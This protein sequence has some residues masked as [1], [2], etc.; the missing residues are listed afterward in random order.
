MIGRAL[1]A[2]LL[3]VIA[4]APAL[5]EDQT[6][7]IVAGAGALAD[8]AKSTQASKL[9]L[10][11]VHAFKEEEVRAAIG[12]HVREIDEK[13]ASPAR[14]DDAA[15]YVGAFYR[16]AGFAKVETSFQISGDTVTVTI[17]EGPR[18]LLRGLTFVGN[19]TYSE[20]QLF[21]YMIGA[22]P[23][24]LKKE[25]DMFPYNA[26]EI[27][28]GA[29]RAHAF[30]ESE[31]FLDAKV[32]PA[33]A[34]ISGDGTRADVRVNVEERMRYTFGGLS[35][36]GE[37]IFPVPKLLVAMR[38]RPD[39][40]FSRT[41]V[42]AMQ[43][44]LESFYRN[45]GYI[46]IQIEAI[47][48]PLAATVVN[49]PR[50]GKHAEVAIAFN[51]KPGPQHRFDGV[52]VNNTTPV[53]PRLRS[54]FL[55]LRF[56][57]LSGEIYSP[58]KVD[59]TYREMLRTG[60]FT[61]LRLTPTPLPDNTV[62]LDFTAEE[63]KA[64]EVGFTL[65]FGTYDGFKVGTRL[66]DRDFLGN[67]R[68]LSFSAD[69]TQR[70]LVAELLYVD[71]WFLEKPYLNLRA[72]IYSAAREEQGYSKNEV[73][74]RT[75]MNWRAIPHLEI[76]GFVQGSNTKITD[77][78]IDPLLL[79]P[80]DYNF[81]SLGVQQTTDFRD[82]EVSPKRGWIFSTSADV[83]TIDNEQAFTR[84]IARFSW[85]IPVGKCQLALGARAGALQPIAPSIPIDLRFFNGGATTVRSFAE[86]QLGPKD[87]GG[88]PLGG[89]FFT[90]ENIEF[91]FPIRE[92]FQGAVFVDAGN[93]TGW[94]SAGFGDMR[95]ALGLGIRYALPVGPLRIDYGVNPDRREDED[96]GAL[97]ISFGAA[98]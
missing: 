27:A 65:G 25:P 11:G 62:R 94:D 68:P 95:Y 53:K 41:K 34:K 9:K 79:G 98:F 83:G 74:F 55:P 35:F 72:K 24:R 37:P 5:A 32:E 93:L 8:I 47:A 54:S 1:A 90:A 67:G 75:E 14:G 60:L 43:R 49:L 73:G 92:G 88:N 78:T 4:A 31:G 3:G 39:G 45:N 13:G 86:R 18:T 61:N 42:I 59:E 44:N 63:A 46:L 56:A 70:G 12:E 89:E 20:E 19:K 91:T 10:A 85:Y 51:I 38:E 29:E 16:K 82:N 66:A 97:H 50:I 71:P 80:L 69:W 58:E 84:E 76:G 26:G 64:R 21:E 33:E 52:T 87:K 96:F 15:F 7:N 57:H 2:A 48:D 30:Y 36:T 81:L 17:K 40:P 22:K 77:F 23:E 6:A 28:A